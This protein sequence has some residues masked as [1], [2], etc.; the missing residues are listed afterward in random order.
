L[1][2]RAKTPRAIEVSSI[3]EKVQTSLSEERNLVLGAQILLG[4]QY[5][6]AFHP[7]FERLEDHTR[8]GEVATLG[9]LLVTM[10]LLLAPAP[11]HRIAE[12]GNATPRQ[13]RYTNRMIASALLPFALA[14]GANVFIATER[15]FGTGAALILGLATGATALLAWFGPELVR[16]SSRRD[17]DMRAL[18]I[19]DQGGERTS[20]K[21]KINYLLTESRIILPGAQA[22]LGFQFAAF[23]TDAFE[24]LPQTSKLAHT[25]SLLLIAAA[26]ILLMTPAP[27]H[28]IVYGGEDTEAFDRIATRLVLGAL[29]PLGLGL[30]GE[31]YVVLAKIVDAWSAIIAACVVVVAFLGLWFGY[32][33]LARR[34]SY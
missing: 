30:A 6:A 33:L 7:G 13:H 14:L 24:K 15:P 2:H 18:P 10:L 26:V 28:R 32:P 34:S 9:L 27:Y 22:L 5:S 1:S 16:A 4:F 8:W 29:V 12:G 23:L 25:A 17:A 20:L 3:K 11:F 31:L 21:E 19:L